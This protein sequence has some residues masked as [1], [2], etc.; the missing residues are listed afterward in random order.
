[1]FLRVARQDNY[2]YYIYFKVLIETGMRKGEV[3]A[4]QW[5]NVDFKKGIISIEKTLD[6]QA[7]DG[8]ELF[9]LTKTY[10]SKRK[11]KI[12]DSLLKELKT[13]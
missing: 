11:I 1:M 5:K 7:K 8:E 3:A 2:N 10:D 4:L 9:G 12:G 13:I 6:F